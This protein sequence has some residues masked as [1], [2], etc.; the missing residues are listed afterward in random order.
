M[1][2]DCALDTERSQAYILIMLDA[3]NKPSFGMAG[4]LKSLRSIGSCL[5]PNIGSASGMRQL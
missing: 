2:D 1:E 3:Q 5:W 4:P